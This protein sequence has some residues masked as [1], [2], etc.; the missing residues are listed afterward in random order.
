MHQA[1]QVDVQWPSILLASDVDGTFWSPG[2]P[3]TALCEAYHR[4]P[5][6]VEVLFA[7]SRTVAELAFLAQVLQADCDFI[8][9]NGAVAV[10]HDAD[11]ARHLVGAERARVGDGHAFVAVWADESA[12]V[13]RAVLEARAR[14]RAPVRLL[15]ELEPAARE[16][17]VGTDDE[18]GRACSR[19]ASV[20]VRAERG[21]ALKSWIRELRRSGHHVASGGRWLAVWRGAS[22]GQALSR[23]LHARKLAGRAPAVV[24]AIGD[25]EN[26]VSLLQSAALRFAVPRRDGTV[27]PALRGLGHVCIASHVGTAGWCEVVSSLGGMPCRS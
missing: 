1:S 16:R 4:R 24:A 26:D 19:R 25:G 8:A 20:L 7:S 12:R 22:K 10:T 3:M 15:E 27:H 21:A 23:Y 5:R 6:R 11:V 2:L 13:R 14:H 18:V 9:E 17:L